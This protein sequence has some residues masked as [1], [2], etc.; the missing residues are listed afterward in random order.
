MMRVLHGIFFGL[1]LLGVLGFL[2]WSTW[3]YLTRFEE[4]QGQWESLA[5]GFSVSDADE[6]P[7]DTLQSQAKTIMVLNPLVRFI[8]IARGQHLVVFLARSG[9]R[10]PKDLTHRS[11]PGFNP[12]PW[13]HHLVTIERP[14]R[15]TT[16]RIAVWADPSWSRADL[17]SWFWPGVLLAVT[18]FLGIVFVVILA[19]LDRPDGQRTSTD[20]PRTTDPAAPLELS[21]N[22]NVLE[23]PRAP[24]EEGGQGPGV[25][26][27]TGGASAGARSLFDANGLVWYDFLRERLESELNRTTSENQDLCLVFL[28]V[29]SSARWEP[30][31]AELI[32]AFFPLRD[33]VFRTPNGLA[34]VI[35]KT[36]F[37]KVFEHVKKL[38][39]DLGASVKDLKVRAGLSARCGRILGAQTL[40]KEAEAALDKAGFHQDQVVGFRAD[41]ELYRE[42][43]SQ[44]G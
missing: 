31:A 25:G 23:S 6:S 17:R 12:I 4:R 1:F 37:E 13:F 28:Q 20:T 21:L 16:F 32:R 44:Q 42:F 41:P 14:Y 35:P 10:V 3:I 30:K 34:L 2:G 7:E 40:I 22:E 11:F 43:V 9:M 38:T 5:A 15:E 29:Q 33:L 18:L 19:L 8:G 36:S 27:S 26:A 39:R 24:T